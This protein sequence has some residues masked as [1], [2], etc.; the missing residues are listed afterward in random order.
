MAI[1]ATGGGEAPAAGLERARYQAAR[2]VRTRTAPPMAASR[3]RSVSGMPRPYARLHYVSVAVC[4]NSRAEVQ[5]KC[6]ARGSAHD[7]VH[8]LRRHHDDL[9]DLLAVD[10]G[11]H[12]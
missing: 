5:R 11:L 6:T 2:R 10:V 7:E 8:E 3:R 9:H 4:D 12:V 1:V